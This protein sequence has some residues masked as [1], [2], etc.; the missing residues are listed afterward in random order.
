MIQKHR[1]P[2]KRWT[3]EEWEHRP[4]GHKL[5]VY[6][7]KDDKV[8]WTRVA[9][10]WIE[11]KTQ[12]EASRKAEEAA[13]RWLVDE[14]QWERF[15]VIHV[16]TSHTQMRRNIFGHQLASHDSPSVNFKMAR[17]WIRTGDDGTVYV[18]DW[19]RTG[20]EKQRKFWDVIKLYS[21]SII[22]EDETKIPYSDELWEKLLRMSKR[23]GEI[24][25]T[26]DEM[27]RDTELLLNA[28]ETILPLKEKDE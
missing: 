21:F 24:Q 19:E 17:T 11:E 7:D 4:S 13:D 27:M 18:R 3:V 20:S 26:M 25:N 23:L 22:D 5:H 10:E 12:E 15:I 28:P 2:T 9:T 6:Y 1:K 14:D 8:F 16:N